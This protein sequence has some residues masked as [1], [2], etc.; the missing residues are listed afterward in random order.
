LCNANDSEG[1]KINEENIDQGALN[2]LTMH[3]DTYY[4]SSRYKG[5]YYI[6]P[7]NSRLTKKRIESGKGVTNTFYN[8]DKITFITN[9]GQKN[10]KGTISY[11]SGIYLLND[12][13]EPV[14]FVLNNGFFTSGT[15]F[16]NHIYVLTFDPTVKEE[17]IL[18]VNLNGEIV[19]KFVL[20][21]SPRFEFRS[22]TTSNDFVYMYSNDGKLLFIDTADNLQEIPLTNGTGKVFKIFPD[23]QGIHVLFYNGVFIQIKQNKVNSVLKLQNES[24]EHLISIQSKIKGKVLHVLYTFDK[25][26]YGKSYKYEGLIRQYSLDDGSVLADFYL[27]KLDNLRLVDFDI[28]N[29]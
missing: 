13:S 10:E 3:K 15:F 29:N 12:K 2:S 25:A 24:N 16:N 6:L 5:D 11:T 17:Q 8:N 22:I 23:Y 21:R 18:K 14:E 20:G 1:K 26:Y 9:W 28:T 7:K 4:I 27:E 19:K